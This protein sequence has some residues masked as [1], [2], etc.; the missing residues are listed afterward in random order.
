M[1]LGGA[2][3]DAHV[4]PT[5]AQSQ[6]ASVFATHRLSPNFH[7]SDLAIVVCSSAGAELY[8]VRSENSTETSSSSTC[9]S[10]RLC[11]R[12]SAEQTQFVP[13]TGIAGCEHLRAEGVDY[14]LILTY[15]SE[16]AGS[17]TL[18]RHN[19]AAQA[20]RLE[21]F[22]TLQGSSAS[23]GLALG[24]L[25]M[26]TIGHQ[27]T[28]QYRANR[29]NSVYLRP[30][31]FSP[32]CATT[33]GRSELELAMPYAPTDPLSRSAL[34]ALFRLYGFIEGTNLSSST[35]VLSGPN[36]TVDLHVNAT[37]PPTLSSRTTKPELIRHSELQV[38]KQPF[39]RGWGRRT[40]C[41]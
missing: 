3:Y 24:G 15:R 26:M 7:R 13:A 14:L 20:W 41:T 35:F 40:F 27:S 31:D 33:E 38:L 30:Y 10:W 22:A 34:P 16:S 28:P 39:P 18:Y 36:N 19:T 21:A 11:G 37:P 8:R 1:H 12:M 9:G 4:H 29:G 25:A 17:S 23:S 2:D 6:R 5:S 32:T